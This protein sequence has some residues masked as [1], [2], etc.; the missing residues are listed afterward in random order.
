LAVR[1]LRRDLESGTT[2]LVRQTAM[3]SSILVAIVL[4]VGAVVAA[5]IALTGMVLAHSPQKTVAEIIRDA[6]AR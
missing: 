5:M 2:R 4:A 1:R 3:T 6:E